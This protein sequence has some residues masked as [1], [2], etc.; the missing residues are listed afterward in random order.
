MCMSLCILCMCSVLHMLL[1]LFT[2]LVKNPPVSCWQ[3]QKVSSG[4]PRASCNNNPF[5]DGLFQTS[6]ILFIRGSRYNNPCN[7]TWN[8]GWQCII[9]N[10]PQP[11]LHLPACLLACLPAQ[12][13]CVQPPPRACSGLFLMWGGFVSEVWGN[14]C[15]QIC[16][17]LRPC[18]LQT[19]HLWPRP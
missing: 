11:A 18:P 13:K 19:S 8:E 9:V 12:S 7:V 1:N 3:T 2:L 4:W 6:T 5:K 14:S 17:F 15:C 10:R 16:P